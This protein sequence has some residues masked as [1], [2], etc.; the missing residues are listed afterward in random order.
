MKQNKGIKM[1]VGKKSM[2]TNPQEMGL[3]RSNVHSTPWA[4][5]PTAP[6]PRVLHR[7]HPVYG[8]AGEEREPGKQMPKLPWLSR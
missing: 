7:V 3:G 6:A 4:R 1:F 2:M 5:G 8:A